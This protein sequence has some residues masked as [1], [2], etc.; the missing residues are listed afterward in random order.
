[1]TQ[2]TALSL[3]SAG[4]HAAQAASADRGARLL[5]TGDALGNVK[6]WRSSGADT[7]PAGALASRRGP[8]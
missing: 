5:W 3:G 1:M 7:P 8:C 6:S 4:R 2:V